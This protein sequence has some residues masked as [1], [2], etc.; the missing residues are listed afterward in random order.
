MQG[1]K[2]AKNPQL[3]GGG[4]GPKRKIAEDQKMWRGRGDSEEP[5]RNPDSCEVV[6]ERD[7]AQPHHWGGHVEHVHRVGVQEDIADGF[8]H[9]LLFPGIK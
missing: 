7:G 9:V 6:V 1:T 2:T 8:T 3:G 5:V 4:R